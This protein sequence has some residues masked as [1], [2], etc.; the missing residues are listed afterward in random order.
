M[1]TEG[2]AITVELVRLA[3]ALLR[4]RR[5]IT[6]SALVT[7]LLALLG[8]LALRR[9]G[10]RATFAPTTPAAP[11]NLSSLAGLAQQFGVNVR[12]V[13]GTPP[14]FF[15][16]LATSRTVLDSAIRTTYR[17][18][19]GRDGRDTVTATLLEY[20]EIHDRIPADA[21]LRAEKKLSR[22][23]DASADNATGIVTIEVRSRYA[24]LAEQVA[25][26][27]V[28]LTNDLNVRMQQAQSA[29]ER[30]FAE[31]QMEDARA[32]LYVS[33]D[34]LRGFLERNRDYQ[35][36]PRPTFEAGRLTRRIS[37]AEGVYAELA[38]TRDQAAIA[39]V[40]NTPVIR[41]IDPA[42]GSARLTPR[43]WQ[44]LLAG[45]VLGGLLGGVLALLAE[46]VAVQRQALPEEFARLRSAAR[47]ALRLRPLMP[48]DD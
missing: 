34:S 10:A 41:P 23:I 44:L 37:L 20:F 5:L 46:Y 14:Q 29:A 48:R 40:Q 24:A 28:D 2:Q 9:Y 42:A 12:D 31:Q 21:M 36:S 15:I 18:P 6:V 45:L 22:A 11:G 43:L 26:R 8:G 27:I 39:S 30:R 47:N 7:V 4:R 33:E 19:R 16:A 35:T 38:Q 3:G 1:T 13:A 25:Q 32:R 17:F